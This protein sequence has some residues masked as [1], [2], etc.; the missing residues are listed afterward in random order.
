MREGAVE[1]VSKGDGKC[2]CEKVDVE[3]Q[4]APRVEAVNS[5]GSAAATGGADKIEG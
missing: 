3:L 1:S 5:Q 4:V 2:G